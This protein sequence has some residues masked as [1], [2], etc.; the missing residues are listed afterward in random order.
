MNPKAPEMPCQL[1]LRQTGINK[2]SS[3]IFPFEEIISRLPL[4]RVLRVGSHTF[5][6]ICRKLMPI[7]L[8]EAMMFRMFPQDRMICRHFS[9]LHFQRNRTI[10]WPIMLTSHCYARR[11]KLTRLINVDVIARIAPPTS[12]LTLINKNR[13][14]TIQKQKL[15]MW[16]Y[17][18]FTVRRFSNGDDGSMPAHHKG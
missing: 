6:S 10:A 9:S 16:H 7:N 15:E 2:M 5:C 4:T 12:H 1:Q 11:R 18:E 8:T 3:A 14:E 17:T 13:M